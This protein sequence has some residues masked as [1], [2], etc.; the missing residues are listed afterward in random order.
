MPTIEEVGL[1]DPAPDRPSKVDEIIAKACLGLGPKRLEKF[2]D[3]E[4]TELA[5]KL[6][7]ENPPDPS[8][9]SE[10]RARLDAV[11]LKFKSENR[12]KLIAKAVKAEP[13]KGVHE[14]PARKFS[15]SEDDHPKRQPSPS[16][17]RPGPPFR[18]VSDTAA[19]QATFANRERHELDILAFNSLKLRVNREGLAEQ[20][21]DLVKIMATVDVV[22][23]SEVP[24]KEAKART[25]QLV[26]LMMME[27]QDGIA[28]EWSFSVSE[29]SGPGNPEVHV[30]LI[31]R[32]IRVVETITHIEANGVALDHAPFS[33]KI[34][35]PRFSRGQTIIVTSVH[36]PPASRGKDRDQQMNAFFKAYST[37][38][39]MR[40][41]EPF[42]FKGAK[43][44]RKQPVA[45]IV[46][47]D[48][49]GYP[50]DRVP[51]LLE[52][53]WGYPLVGSQ[54]ATSAG[55]KSFDHFVPDAQT[56][57]SYNLSWEVLQLP[58]PQNSAKGEI[59]LSDHDPI[60]LTIK[61]A[62]RLVS[63]SPTLS[64]VG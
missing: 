13:A 28:D 33:I 22:L 21:L 63:D 27:Q 54:V 17:M 48:F 34:N 49:N 18:P 47:G 4:A 39:E 44:A 8:E 20:W 15:L 56:T 23:L 14:A 37:K 31:K 7:I 60:M 3:F 50:L 35:D 61:E 9:D 43:D 19:R 45:H 30:A 6:G 16:K 53:G 29:P 36:F 38:A 64:S 46:A 26:A 58:L 5:V 57:E 11:I 55:C 10:A 62:T 12:D 59:G 24:A 40:M 51:D 2:T 52:L 32:P 42:T 1:P 25:Q 41:N